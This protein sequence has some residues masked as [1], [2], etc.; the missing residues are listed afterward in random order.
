MY[1]DDPTVPSPSA[2]WS[3]TEAA[4]LAGNQLP[5]TWDA[6]TQDLARAALAE[7]GFRLDE[8][9]RSLASA[10]EALPNALCDAF[11]LIEARLDAR[12]GTPAAVE[13]ARIAMENIA[14]SATV[15]GATRARA[16]LSLATTLLRSN[17]VEDAERAC[18]EACTLLDDGIARTWALD[19][20]SQVLSS[21][22]AWEEARHVFPHVLR[23]K[24]AANDRVGIAITAGT[25]ARMELALD[26]PA[27]ALAWLDHYRLDEA[28]D[29][30]A[31]TRVR[32]STA[33]LEA[34]LDLEVAGEAIDALVTSLRLCLEQAASPQHPLSGFAHLALSLA[35]L[36]AG[37]PSEPDLEYATRALTDPEGRARIAFRRALAS[38][39]LFDDTD[40]LAR[41][42][43]DLKAA[44]GGTETEVDLALR[45]APRASAAGRQ[46]DARALLERALAAATAANSSAWIERIARVAVTVDAQWTAGLALR[47][48]GGV[49]VAR[50]R[51][52]RAL[53]ASIVFAD[54]VGF[55]DRSQVLDPAEVM[56]TSQ[57]L[58]ELAV[59]LLQKHRVRPSNYLGDAVLAIAEGEGHRGRAIGFACDYVARAKR[60]SVIRGALAEPWMLTIR[61]GVASGPIVTGPVG[62][63]LKTEYTTIGRTV[64]LAA[65]LQ[66]CAEPGEVVVDA[67]SEDAIEGRARE[68][69]Q[70]KGFRTPVPFV[71]L[72]PGVRRD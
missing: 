51:D 35:A 49:D 27:A 45:L 44:G 7:V 65:R 20:W 71:R 3:V 43:A 39:A 11:R 24:R 17:R 63:A 2:F 57:A 62:N 12:Q 47:R 21:S 38:P 53:D 36:R 6:G 60:A 10:R 46:S 69:V 58:F 61:A 42:D 16:W 66:S 59:P 26:R 32:L 13:G 8:G 40:Y 19:V 41:I 52:I 29:L 14:A 31:L 5:L 55:T 70:L 67:E 48:F 22:G 54:L 33:R 68:S 23:Y 64:N 9:R 30:P 50:S 56:S 18:F 4:S 15:D 25:A 1:P 72:S 28:A 37:Q 34:S